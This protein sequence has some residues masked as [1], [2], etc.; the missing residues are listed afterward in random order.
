MWPN[1][2]NR[3]YLHSS[4]PGQ[5]AAMLNEVFQK[6]LSRVQRK[7]SAEPAGWRG[8]ETHGW[9]PWNRK[10]KKKSHTGALPESKKMEKWFQISTLHSLK[11][12]ASSPLKIGRGR[13]KRKVHRIPTIHFQVQTCC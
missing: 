10:K 3:P 2:L 4:P 1:V 12:T 13:A 8:G 9:N 11:L 6:S 7:R 5:M